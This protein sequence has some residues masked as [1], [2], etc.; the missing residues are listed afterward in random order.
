[1]LSLLKM[2]IERQYSSTYIVFVKKIL[3]K[4]PYDSTHTGA[5][6]NHRESRVAVVISKSTM[7][8]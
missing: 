8:F 3:T 1:M 4:R 5:E 2:L 7:K 6:L